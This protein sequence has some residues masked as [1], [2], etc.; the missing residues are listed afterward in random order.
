[1]EKG[2]PARKDAS[3]G[4]FS[5]EERRLSHVLGRIVV[6]LLSNVWPVDK[7]LMKIFAKK[8]RLE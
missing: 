3:V 7:L 6:P 1:M 8:Q 4:K 2:L 5:S